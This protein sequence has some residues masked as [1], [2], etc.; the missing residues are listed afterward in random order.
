MPGSADAGNGIGGTADKVKILASCAIASSSITSSHIVDG[1]ILNVDIN[2]SAA[3][4]LSK[5]ASCPLARSGHTGTQTASTISD[6]DTEVA[7]NTAVT[8]NTAKI[9]YC[10]TASTKL[11]TIET[12]ATADQSNAEIV[13]AVEAGTDSNTFT[14]ADHSKLDAIEA[15]ATA[16]Q[17]NAEIKAA[18]EAATDS[19]TFTDDDHTKLDAIEASATADQSNAEIKTAY[20]ANSDTNALT[21][22]LS[23]EITANTAKTGI[24]SGQASAITANTAK[25]SYCS[26][27]ST[28]LG[29]IEGSATADQSN[30]EIKTAYEAN[31][32]TNAL[33]CALSAEITANTAKISYC[34]TASTKLATIETSATADQT[35]AQIKTAYEGE[36]CTNA[37]TDALSAEITANTAKISYCSTASTKLG[38][39]EGSATADQTNAE[40]RTAVGAATDSNIFTDANVTTLGNRAPLACPTFTGGIT[41][42]SSVLI[43]QGIAGLAGLTLTTPTSNSTGHVVVSPSGTGTR[44]QIT[45]SNSS[46]PSTNGELLAIGSDIYATNEHAIRTQ[47]TGTGTVRP[48]AVYFDTTKIMQI[49]DATGIDINGNNIDNVQNII[50]DISTT[51]LDVDFAEDQLQ[52]YSVSGD[53]TFTTFQ[54]ITAGKS[55]TIRVTADGTDR[56]L[57]FPANIRWLGTAP[58]TN[59]YTVTA[60]KMAI[61]TFTSFSTDEANILG[62]FALEE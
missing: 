2:A 26:T 10:S 4:A 9:S 47:A 41:T 34:S 61:L 13:A 38:T 6:F 48:L 36:A 18:V 35:G 22:A 52:T 60:S 46:D 24:S 27:A 62:V 8:A 54:N 23:A 19:N 20:E 55:K 11:G 12:S 56:V 40:I 15:S 50:H 59:T 58:D 57:T 14:D 1:A 45:T 21:D 28:K 17:S 42:P 29:T 31:A 32:C 44:G 53:V 5:L 33:T 3:I 37:L 39:I 49:T 25:I 51:G 7:N 43:N 30:A 16:D